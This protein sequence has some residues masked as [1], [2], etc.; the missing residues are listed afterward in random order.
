MSSSAAV[1]IDDVR[2]DDAGA[3]AAYGLEACYRFH[4]YLIESAATVDVGAAV[5]AQLINYHNPK[6]GRDWSGVAW[7][8]PFLG[9][10]GLVRYERVVIFTTDGPQANYDGVTIPPDASADRFAETNAY[11][12]A[13]AREVVRLQLAR[14]SEEA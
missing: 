5:P 7:E 14:G 1:Y 13:V 11:L 4:G 9:R 12:V 6:Q 3:L 2:T 10:N 8:W